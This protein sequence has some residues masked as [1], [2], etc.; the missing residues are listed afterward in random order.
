MRQAKDRP[1]AG[2]F[3]K[4]HHLVFA[5]AAGTPLDD[6]NARPQFRVIT[7]TAGLEKAWVPRELRH[8]FVSPLSARGVPTEA[9]AL[10]VG[11]SRRPRLG[12]FTGIKSYLR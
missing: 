10:L 9:I 6:H 8:T 4:D 12:W 7:E 11:I 5:A 3:R 1:S 2:P